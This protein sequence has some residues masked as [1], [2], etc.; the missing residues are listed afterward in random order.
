MASKYMKT[1]EVPQHR[2]HI[3]FLPELHIAIVL[4]QK[5][6]IIC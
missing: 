2:Q 1:L 5:R 3:V 6:P 4:P